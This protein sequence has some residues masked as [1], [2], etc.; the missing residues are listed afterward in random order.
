MKLIPYTRRM[1]NLRDNVIAIINDINCR[2][3]FNIGYNKNYLSNI[4]EIDYFI[5]E[6]RKADEYNTMVYTERLTHYNH[7]I[8]HWYFYNNDNKKVELFLL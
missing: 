8:W 5:N 1:Y 7:K 4:N 3:E 2:V 6:I